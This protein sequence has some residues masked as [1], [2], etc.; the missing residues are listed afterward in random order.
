M[1][2]YSL[3]NND[4]IVAFKDIPDNSIDLVVTDPPYKITKGGCSKIKNGT[5]CGGFLSKRNSLTQEH[6]KNGK[7]FKHNEIKFSDWVPEVF[8]VLKDQSHCYIMVNDR[9][10]QEILNEGTKAGF[11]IQ[12]ILIWK[13]DTHT[14]N[15]YYLKNSEFIV[16]FRKGKAKSINNMGTKSIIEINNIKRGHKQHPT[17]KPLELL[18]L[19]IDNSSKS[20]EIVL[21]P[22]MGSGSAGVASILLDRWFIGIEKDESFFEVA[23]DRINSVSTLYDNDHQPCNFVSNQLEAA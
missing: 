4:C 16:M 5:E 12:N 9:N 18:K 11:K 14:P 8:R 21:D 17:E 22:F 1:I 2:K 23:E 19:L 3:I 13:K 10:M 6:S 20:E 7:L 15:R